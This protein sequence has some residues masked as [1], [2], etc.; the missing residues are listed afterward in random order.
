MKNLIKGV[1]K[2]VYDN[3]PY[4]DKAYNAHI[5]AVRMYALKLASKLNADKTIVEVAALLHDTGKIKDQENHHIES[6]KIARK[7]LENYG[8]DKKFI[9]DVIHCI[10]VHRASK[11]D[12]AKTIEAQIIKDADGIAFLDIYAGTWLTFFYFM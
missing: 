6:A 2:Y 10:L 9:E 12:K 3:S 4:S 5:E 7:L 1:E 11:K 8:C